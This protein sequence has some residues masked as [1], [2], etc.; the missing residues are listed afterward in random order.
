MR[1]AERYPAVMP[2]TVMLACFTPTTARVTSVF[3]LS[4]P[5][6]RIIPATAAVSR[7]S[8]RSTVSVGKTLRTEL[9]SSPEPSAPLASTRSLPSAF[10]PAE[11]PTTTKS[12]V[13]A[14]RSVS[15]CR[16]AFCEIPTDAISAPVLS[17]TAAIMRTVRDI[18][19]CSSVAV[20]T[21]R[22]LMR[23]AH[24]ARPQLTH[25]IRPGGEPFIVSNH[26]DGDSPP[27]LFIK[28]PQHRI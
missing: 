9:L 13:A 12:T 17:A 11:A 6:G 16:A 10:A 23:I 7:R 8:I 1:A 28:D 5:T 15:I 19:V 22:S 3:T 26:D 25:P 20:S 21:S 14:A 4:P 2:L 18:R 27:R 24:L